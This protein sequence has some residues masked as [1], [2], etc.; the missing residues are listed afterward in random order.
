MEGSLSGGGGGVGGKGIP[1]RH[2][3][4][5]LYRNNFTLFLILISAQGNCNL[6]A[7]CKFLH[8]G[9]AGTGPGHLRVLKRFKVI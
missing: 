7:S 5:V 9:P 4:K 2:W 1:C 6:G 3:S 8:L